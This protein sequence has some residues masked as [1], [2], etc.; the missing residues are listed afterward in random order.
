MDAQLVK[1]EM[2]SIDSVKTNLVPVKVKVM[3]VAVMVINENNRTGCKLFS[4]CMFL[5]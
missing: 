4:T 5:F 2:Y 1:L 3:L